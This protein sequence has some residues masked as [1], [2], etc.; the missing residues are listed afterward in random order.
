MFCVILS[1][2]VFCKQLQFQVLPQ[3][4]PVQHNIYIYIRIFIYI[5]TTMYNYSL[6]VDVRVGLA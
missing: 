5:Y 6:L 1:K 2:T 3:R 4:Q